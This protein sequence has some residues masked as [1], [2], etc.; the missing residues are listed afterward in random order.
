ME[1]DEELD[2]VVLTDWVLL[3]CRGL[4]FTLLL[5]SCLLGWRAE[6]LLN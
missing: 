1:T 6:L 4:R 5:G 2:L 3:L